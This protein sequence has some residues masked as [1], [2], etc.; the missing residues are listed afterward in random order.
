MP[1]RKKSKAA[2][3]KAPA[4]SKAIAAPRPVVHFEIGCADRDR[5]VDFY[6]KLFGW[7]TE[8]MGPVVRV[9]T[10]EKGIGGNITAL[11][12]QAFQYTMFYVEVEDLEDTLQQAAK[13]G[14]KTMVPPVKIP[15]GMFAWMLD[16]E[17]NTIGL[18]QKD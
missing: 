14:G 12:Y 7:T 6:S 2:A 9:D 13:L 1:T 3:R 8:P 4:R 11:G 15:A 16:P 18:W 17:G 10:G 5:A